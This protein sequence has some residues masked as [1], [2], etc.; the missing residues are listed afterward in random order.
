MYRAEK[1]T[2][3]V[4]CEFR[5]LLSTRKSSVASLFSSR[6]SLTVPLFH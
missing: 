4:T 3:E 5:K 1:E 6:R 2:D